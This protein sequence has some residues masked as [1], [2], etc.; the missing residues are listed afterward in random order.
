MIGR[1]TTNPNDTADTHFRGRLD[2]IQIYGREI[3]ADESLW[4]YQHPGEILPNSMNVQFLHSDLDFSGMI[5][6]YDFL[7]IADNWLL[8]VEQ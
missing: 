3:T 2:D 5:D 6:L 1:R 8:C 7:I 4:L